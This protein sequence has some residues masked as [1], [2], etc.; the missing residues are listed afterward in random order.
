[1]KGD[2]WIYARSNM[3]FHLFAADADQIMSSLYSSL[4]LLQNHTVFTLGQN[5]VFPGADV[6][7]D[8][9]NAAATLLNVPCESPKLV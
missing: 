1:M 5:T 2:L 7:M 6:C 8:P 9:A 3:V 4:S